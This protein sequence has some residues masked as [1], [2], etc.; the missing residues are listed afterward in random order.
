MANY[1][2]K[3]LKDLKNL[4]TPAFIYLFISVLIF[5]VIAVQNFG[6]TTKYCIGDFECYLPNT[7]IMFVFKAIYILFWTFILNSLCKAGYREISWFI[8]L[9]PILLLFIIL[10]LVIVTYTKGIAMP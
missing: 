6:N 1:F 7:F 4:C 9:L 8:V 3:Y 2:D 5:V 10:G